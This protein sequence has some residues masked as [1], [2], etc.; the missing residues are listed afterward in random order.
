MLCELD[1]YWKRAYDD[2][3]ELSHQNRDAAARTQELEKKLDA[4]SETLEELEQQMRALRRENTWLRRMLR[5]NLYPAIAD[6][7][8]GETNLSSTVPPE[9]FSRLI[10]GN[11]PLPL[12]GV[13]QPQPQKMSRQ[14]QLLAD[15]RRQVKEHG[16]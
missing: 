12:N 9:A 10:E 13:Q 5:E 2:S 7:L 4:L 15:M 16:K 11:V 1:G 3:V 8:L 14:E 6:Q